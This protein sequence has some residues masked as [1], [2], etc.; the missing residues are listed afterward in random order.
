VNVLYVE[1]HPDLEGEEMSQA[2]RYAVALK[3]IQKA[4]KE[5]MPEFDQ[6]ALNQA[7]KDLDGEPVA[8]YERVPMMEPQEAAPATV[9]APNQKDVFPDANANPAPAGQGSSGGYYHGT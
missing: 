1:A 6:K 9:P 3:L 4:T 8:V 5:D 2:D 7:L